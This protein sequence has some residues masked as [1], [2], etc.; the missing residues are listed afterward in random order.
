MSDQPSIEDQLLRERMVARARRAARGEETNIDRAEARHEALW[1][2]VFSLRTLAPL[3][4]AVLSAFTTPQV[5]TVLAYN[6]VGVFVV[7]AVAS[8]LTGL[9]GAIIGPF[10]T[11]AASKTESATHVLG[12]L[13]LALVGMDSGVTPLFVTG[14]FLALW[15]FAWM[16]LAKTV[17]RNS[18]YARLRR[19]NDAPKA[20]DII[21]E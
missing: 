17:M 21:I 8:L 15:P 3:F 13:L 16:A 20:P 11:G 5:Y 9:V 18:D 2:R 10:V 14:A 19:A 4:V 1:S 6:F 7:M 12:G